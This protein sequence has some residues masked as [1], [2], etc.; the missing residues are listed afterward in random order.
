MPKDVCV[1]G[2]LGSIYLLL[3]TRGKKS[4]K[5]E[6]QNVGWKQMFW[7]DLK[8]SA[9]DCFLGVE[10]RYFSA[11]GEMIR[12]S[13]TR[14]ERNMLENKNKYNCRVREIQG[15]AKMKIA[16]SLLT[17]LREERDGCQHL[18]VFVCANAKVAWHQQQ[19]LLPV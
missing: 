14:G 5:K 2:L 4:L 19:N 12:I 8:Y 16:L 18:P 3:T 13:L 7:L 17:M 9:V 1:L 11:F 10:L 6:R 15:F